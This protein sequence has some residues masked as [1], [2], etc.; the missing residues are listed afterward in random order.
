[1]RTKLDGVDFLNGLLRSDRCD[2]G[3]T[4]DGTKEDIMVESDQSKSS[5]GVVDGSVAIEVDGIPRCK[6]DHTARLSILTIFSR[7]HSW[8]WNIL[9]LTGR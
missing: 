9:V 2:L 7:R 6:L 4:N 5:L 8:P 3:S 1:V